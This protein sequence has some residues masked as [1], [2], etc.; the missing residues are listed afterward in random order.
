MERQAELAILVGTNGTGK[1]TA[2]KELLTMNERNLIIPSSRT[3]TAWS[4]LPELKSSVVY[5]ADP[6][7][8]RREIPV[9]RVQD[10]QTF[11]GNRVLHVDGNAKVFEAVLDPKRGYFNGGLILDDFR[12]YI[13]TKGSLSSG[14]DGLFIGRRHRML[15]IYLACHSFQDISADLFRFDPTLYVGYTTLPPNDAVQGKV[16]KWRELLATIERVNRTNAARPEGKRY[17]RE[18]FEPA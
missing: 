12:R 11:T 4:G 7:N 15:D 14:V 5:E 1:S 18:A 17:Y 13:Y 3:D 16:A 8:P 9:V 10:L 6:N 2:L